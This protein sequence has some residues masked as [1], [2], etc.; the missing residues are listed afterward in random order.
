MELK[1]LLQEKKIELFS[2]VEM[3][4]STHQEE[5]IGILGKDWVMIYN[6]EAT[7]TSRDSI[8][9]GWRRHVWDGS[10]VSMHLQYMHVHLVNQGCYNLYLMVIYGDNNPIKLRDLWEEFRIVGMSLGISKLDGRRRLQHHS[11]SR[12]TRGEW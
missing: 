11:T 12:G 10:L 6:W 9:V 4:T 7:G 3:L 2:I 5:A 8:W 1:K